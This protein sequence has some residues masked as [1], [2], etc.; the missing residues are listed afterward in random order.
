MRRW[1]S[2]AES[3]SARLLLFLRVKEWYEGDLVDGKRKGGGKLID[4][5]GRDGK[6]GG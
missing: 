4:F 3:I 1:S 5:I 6:R 2:F